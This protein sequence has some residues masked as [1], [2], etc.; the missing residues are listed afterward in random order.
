MS[1]AIRKSGSVIVLSSTMR[2]ASASASYMAQP[3]APG[4]YIT[5]TTTALSRA[6]PA[7]RRSTMS[8]MTRG[9]HSGSG[10]GI[11]FV[12][13]ASAGFS[14]QGRSDGPAQA[15]RPARI[16]GMR[17]RM[18]SAASPAPRGHARLRLGRRQVRRSWSGRRLG[19]TGGSGHVGASPC[20]RRRCA[21]PSGARD[22]YPS[23]TSS[24]PP[25]LASDS[26]TAGVALRDA[27]RR[28]DVRVERHR[29]RVA[30]VRGLLDLGALAPLVLRFDLDPS[31]A[32]HVVLTRRE[33][34]QESRIV[35][36][37]AH[38]LLHEHAQ[39]PPGLTVLV[40]EHIRVRGGRL[41]VELEQLLARLVER[42]HQ[43]LAHAAGVREIPAVLVLPVGVVLQLE[44]VVRDLAG[45]ALHEHLVVDNRQA[46]APRDDALV[47]TEARVVD[48]DRLVDGRQLGDAGAAAQVRARAR[49]QVLERH[50]RVRVLV[51]ELSQH[52]HAIDVAV[53][54]VLE[55]DRAVARRADDVRV[56]PRGVFGVPV[57]L[58]PL[59]PL[60][61]EAVVEAAVG[62]VGVAGLDEERVGVRQRALDGLDDRARHAR[63][64]VGHERQVILMDPLQVLR[65][66]R[67]RGA[68]AP[69]VAAVD[70][71]LGRVALDEA[72][73]Q[74]M[75]VAQR[76]LDL[77]DPLLA[78]AHRRRGHHAERVRVPQAPPEDRLARRARLP[79]PLAAADGDALLALLDRQARFELDDVEELLLLPRR[80]LVEPL[81]QEDVDVRAPPLVQRLELALEPAHQT[82]ARMLAERSRPSSSAWT[83]S[84]KAGSEP[85]KPRTATKD[86]RGAASAAQ[87]GLFGSSRTS[88]PGSEPKESEF[89]R[90]W[91][92]TEA[93]AV[94]A[95]SAIELTK[96][97][98]YSPRRSSEVTISP[99]DPWTL[100]TRHTSATATARMDSFSAS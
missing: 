91:W 85:R 78:L 100:S 84:T 80:G 45:V 49:D 53:A 90:L 57:Q 36:Q 48:A 97:I 81:A 89:Q 37:V 87:L 41:R 70:L 14:S 4:R 47:P 74:R 43:A 33:L 72:L 30:P 58:V 6:A 35:R 96:R 3:H 62:R 29:D 38:A 12:C 31:I 60:R 86:A 66:R 83:V 64:L 44:G 71:D 59:V 88:Q 50:Q 67:R 19:R 79:R 27:N 61:G 32:V 16:R 77:V 95:S 15:A 13:A 20:R 40:G 28:G 82:L 56:V 75:S 24:G 26:V 68:D 92:V 63:G 17:V 93:S 51:R 8:S 22:R 7:V 25:Q 65:A 52:A 34:A 54:P 73:Q 10:S 76:A 1:T 5:S 46:N 23:G 18:E 39:V 69:D 21:I 11:G 2:Y 99:R 55:L 94:S 42:V 98:A 9:Y